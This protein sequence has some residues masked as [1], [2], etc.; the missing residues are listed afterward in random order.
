MRK[1][2]QERIAEQEAIK[3]KRAADFIADM[4]RVLPDTSE[5]ADA[6]QRATD[7]FNGVDI[8]SQ[9]KAD[10]ITNKEAKI[11]QLTQVIADATI[12]VNQKQ[13]TF[14]ATFSTLTSKLSGVDLKD[15]L[16]SIGGKLTLTK[17]K[18]APDIALAQKNHQTSSRALMQAKN[19]KEK[20]E[21][22][23]RMIQETIK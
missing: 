9:K 1:T 17:T 16:K 14:D 5:N 8:T 10:I 2:L 6:R 4:N 11:A 22:R 7:A 12:N 23:L 18:V 15:G 20:L 3:Q 13:Q 19:E 21:F